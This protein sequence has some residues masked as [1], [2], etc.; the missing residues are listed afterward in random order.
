MTDIVGVLGSL[1]PV[2]NSH[3][4]AMA[5]LIGAVIIVAAMWLAPRIIV[6][7]ES[8]INIRSRLKDPDDWAS[9]DSFLRTSDP[10]LWR[11]N[12]VFNRLRLDYLNSVRVSSQIR[13]KET[14]ILMLFLLQLIALRAALF[15]VRASTYILPTSRS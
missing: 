6:A 10:V 5:A 9:E 14:P 13:R 7:T 2:L 4:W 11:Q 8:L 1:F 15:S 12:L 3:P